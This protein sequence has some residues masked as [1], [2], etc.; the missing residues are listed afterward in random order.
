MA[1]NGIVA[2]CFELFVCV[3]TLVDPLFCCTLVSEKSNIS[4]SSFNA[5]IV[6]VLFGGINQPLLDSRVHC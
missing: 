3:C 5:V 4:A 1:D 2:I 6:F